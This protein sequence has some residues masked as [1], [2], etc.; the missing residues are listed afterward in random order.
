MTLKPFALGPVPSLANF[1]R[2]LKIDKSASERQQP[3]DVEAT[4][5]PT[6]MSE[7]LLFIFCALVFVSYL[8]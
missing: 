3:S 1:L 4:D 7:K 5:Q 6:G 2:V 8:V